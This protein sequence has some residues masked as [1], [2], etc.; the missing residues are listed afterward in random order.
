MLSYKR[1][2]A[3]KQMVKLNTQVYN[4]TRTFPKGESFSLV[5]Q[6]RRASISVLSN[7][8]EGYGRKHNADFV[9]FI[10]MSRGSLYELDAQLTA[11]EAIGY[12]S[13][14]QDLQDLAERI[15]FELNLIINKCE[16]NS[17]K[18]AAAK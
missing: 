14:T 17:T 13:S 10:S 2:S 16:E 1:T 9:H 3:W 11:S 5:D 8:A 6:M 15:A 12:T 18:K 7:F 4:L